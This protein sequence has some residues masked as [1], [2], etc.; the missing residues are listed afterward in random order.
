M[1]NELQLKRIIYFFNGFQFFFAL[2]WWVPIFYAY[3][4]QAGLNDA[5][6]FKIQSYYYLIFCLL[7]IP[8]GYLA[9]K[10]GYKLCLKLGGI[11]LLLANIWVPIDPS[12]F[13]FLIHFSLIA[14]ARSFVSGA[15]SAYL[16]EVLKS[17][18]LL[19][20]YKEAE[21]RAR[22]FSLV[23]KVLCWGVVGYTMQWMQELPYWLTALNALI[24]IIFAYK[25]PDLKIA[26]KA[27]KTTIASIFLILKSHPTLLLIMLQGVAL[28][29]L[30]RICQVNLFQPILINKGFDVLSFGMV[31]AAMTIFEAIGS[32]RSKW[33]RKFLNDLYATFFFTCCI[34][35]SF[36]VMSLNDL[37][38]IDKKVATLVSLCFFSFVIGISFPIQR[39]LVNEAIPS[40]ELRATLLSIESI[41]DRAVNSLVASFLSVVLTTGKL[42]V[43]LE[44]AAFVTILSV[45]IVTLLIRNKRQKI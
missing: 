6:I 40:P 8:T 28:F 27:E 21:G 44:Q 17:K 38:F 31:M 32:Y 13:G 35:V 29:V 12:Y 22:S 36:Y 24:S 5:E 10:I 23:G 34:G 14:L 18:N 39:Q 42:L 16:Y 43:F 41:I 2:L 25:L 45:F 7:E 33:V 20:D 19:D 3:Q 37:A 11:T 30:A 15:S 26:A 4:K 1:K 9:D